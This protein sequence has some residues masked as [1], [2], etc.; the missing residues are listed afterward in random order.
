MENF[1]KKENEFQKKR[2]SKKEDVSKRKRIFQKKKFFS[3]RGKF[4]TLVEFFSSRRKFSVGFLIFDFFYGKWSW[5]KRIPFMGL[6]L[7]GVL[8]GLTSFLTVRFTV[9]SIIV[10]NA[11]ARRSFWWS[12]ASW[13]M[14]T[15]RGRMKRWRD[16]FLTSRRAWTP[17]GI[18]DN[19]RKPE[20]WTGGRRR[21]RTQRPPNCPSTFLINPLA[22]RESSSP[23]SRTISPR[24]EELSI[25]IRY[26]TWRFKVSAHD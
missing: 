24:L 19:R 18:S 17:T 8:L 13:I 20:R 3:K 6:L 16:K 15:A 10:N 26:G 14:R 11:T 7:C 5:L 21:R 22:I 23:S 2:F 9:S 25:P 4:W 1:F 12:G